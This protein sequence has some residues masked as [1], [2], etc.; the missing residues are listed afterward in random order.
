MTVLFWII[1]YIA[2][3]TEIVMCCIFCGTFLA[4]EK[5]KKRKY[6]IFAGSGLS[7]LLI[8][9]LNKIEIFSF[10]NSI[11]VLIVVWGMQV[12]IYKARVMVCM[13]L[14][15]IYTVILAAIDFAVA[16]FTAAIIHVDANYL[17]NNQSISRI[18]CILLSKSLLILIVVTIDKLLKKS[19]FFMKKYVAVLFAYSFFMLVSLHIMVELNIKNKNP[20]MELFLVIFFITS[21]LIELVVFYFVIK[22]GENYEQR[23]KAEL[24]EMKS[25]MLQ[26]SLDETEQTFKLWRRSI[27]DYKNNIIALRQLAEDENMEGIREY[28]DHE[29]ELIQKKMFYIKTG[30]SVVDAIVNTKQSLAEEKGITFVVNATIPGACI[31]SELDMANILGNLTDNAIEAS[32]GE[33]E[34]YIDLTIKREKSF[35]IIKIISKYSGM[36]AGTSET[37]KKNRKFHGIGME[38]VKSIV[39]KYEGEF[40]IE[41]KGADVVVKILIPN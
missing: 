32:E 37:T 15:V 5:S 39:K 21:M 14:T 9:A 25:R 8:I 20:E 17:L 41:Q 28:L 3:F 11:L 13:A 18:L 30:S 7:A 23:Q 16:Y 27:H 40:S 19:N 26:K 24:M 31:V 38:S 2:S 6:L 36:F 10:V 29:N 33:E 34:P 12:F 1:E 22:T 4:K 35:L